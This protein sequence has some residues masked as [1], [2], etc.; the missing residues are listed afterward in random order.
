[1]FHNLKEPLQMRT[2]IY[3]IPNKLTVEWE[4]EVNAIIDTWTNQFVTVEE[5]TH[6]VLTKGVNHAIENQGIAWIIN[7]RNATSVFKQEIQALIEST[8]FPTFAKIGI[9]YFITISPK[10]VV[11]NLSV[12]K[13]K[14]KTGPSGINLVECDSTEDAIEWLKKNVM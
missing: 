4:P 6:A 5:F 13:Y 14:A 8:I 9:K 3:K 11:A 2:R 12:K 7:S 10:D 1:M